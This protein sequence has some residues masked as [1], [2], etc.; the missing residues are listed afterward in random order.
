MARVITLVLVLVLVLVLQHS[1]ENRSITQSL[2]FFD[3]LFMYVPK[4]VFK[5]PAFFILERK[6]NLGMC[7]LAPYVSHVEFLI[8]QKKEAI[9]FCHFFSVVEDT[10]LIEVMKI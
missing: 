1:N 7:C 8:C 2:T 4:N 5:Y 10:V 6:H 9:D 3:C